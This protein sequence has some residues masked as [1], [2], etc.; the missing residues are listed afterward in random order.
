MRGV[1]HYTN[2]EESPPGTYFVVRCPREDGHAAADK[3]AY[4]VWI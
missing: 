1:R 2:L 3:S 4:I